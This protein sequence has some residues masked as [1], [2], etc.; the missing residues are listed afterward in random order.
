MKK[1]L[2]V[3]ISTCVVGMVHAADTA[4]VTNPVATTATSEAT[5][6]AH[7]GTTN[8]NGVT[9]DEHGD[10]KLVAT[11]DDAAVSLSQNMKIK[12]QSSH[13]ADDKLKIK[14]DINYPQIQGKDLSVG[15]KEFNQQ[16]EKIVKTETEQFKK[17]VI[18]DVPH[19]QTLPDEL[20]NNTL[21]V[22]YDVNVVKPKDQ[23][24]ISVRLS[25]EGMQA[26][27]AHPY[28][29]NKVV[30]FDLKTGKILALNEIFKSNAKYLKL[31]AE[32]TRK[33]LDEKLKKD[34][35]MVA[36]GTTPDVKNFKN[37]NLQSDSLL[38]TFDEYQVAPYVY[39]TQEVEIPYSVLQ[40]IL[41]S[42]TDVADCVKDS[43]RCQVV[44]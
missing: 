28:H 41:S 35:W 39:G 4:P 5:N 17:S 19:M 23:T 30:N 1:I 38:I 10:V 44:G 8:A 36:A 27:R 13:V 14:M 33:A 26:G 6:T 32:Y 11:D 9:I 29:T 31:L 43:N 25:F 2:S 15:A 34:N 40:K 12:S 21:S 24:L 42:K 7:V 16:I 20:K 18:L 3:L 37:W 22:D